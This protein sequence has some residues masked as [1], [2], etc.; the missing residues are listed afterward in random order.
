[1]AAVAALLT[2][3]SVYLYLSSLKSTNTEEKKTEVVVAVKNILSQTTVTPEMVRKKLMPISAVLPNAIKNSED[4]IGKIVKCDI[5][6]GE[7]ILEGK[8]FDKEDSDAGLAFIL[9]KG[10]RAVTMMVDLK[11]GIN[12]LIRPGNFVDVMTIVDYKDKNE[13]NENPEKARL[14][15]EKIKVVAVGTLT[16]EVSSSE[17]PMYETVTLAVTPKDALKLALCDYSETKPQITCQLLLRP[18]DDEVLSGGTIVTVN[19]II[20]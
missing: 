2:C 18:Q 12:G 13:N 10:T 7:M 15:L 1:M 14:I 3:I 5:F 9:P 16:N 4:V 6:E 8:F 20:Q 19:D 11:S 17:M